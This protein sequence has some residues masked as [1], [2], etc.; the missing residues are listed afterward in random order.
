MARRTSS[1][2]FVAREVAS[3]QRVSRTDLTS[4][5]VL[6]SMAVG[7]KG[8]EVERHVVATVV[9]PMVNIEM[10]Y[11]GVVAML[12][13][14]VTESLDRSRESAHDVVFEP[15]RRMVG[16]VRTGACK[17]PPLATLEACTPRDGYA[18]KLAGAA[19]DT[20]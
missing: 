4:G 19:L 13:G 12:T 10:R 16:D 11:S 3:D 5:S 8:H 15:T 18:A 2:C 6:I 20:R 7:T 9:V 1:E 14:E 17:K